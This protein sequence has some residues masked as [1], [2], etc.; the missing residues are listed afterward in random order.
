LVEGGGVVGSIVGA[1]VVGYAVVERY[2]TNDQ[3]EMGLGGVEA[4]VGKLMCIKLTL[5]VGC[6]VAGEVIHEPNVLLSKPPNSPPNA[7]ISAPYSTI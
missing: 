3:L 7:T 6:T 4:I 2:Q 1:D 5:F